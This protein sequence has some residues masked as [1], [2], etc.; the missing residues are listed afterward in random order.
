MLFI[1]L[2]DKES[3]FAKHML[4]SNHSFGI[5]TNSSVCLLLTADERFVAFENLKIQKAVLDPRVPFV[6]EILPSSFSF[7]SSVYAMTNASM[8]LADF[9]NLINHKTLST[10]IY[11]ITY[12]CE[13]DT[14]TYLEEA[15]SAIQDAHP[16]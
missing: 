14:R 4:S 8:W 10:S 1:S 13:R 11:L 12:W 7:T 16:S 5:S 2:T 15:P 3:N 6:N 9:K